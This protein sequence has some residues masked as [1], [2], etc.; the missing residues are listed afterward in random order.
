MQYRV[1]LFNVVDS[2]VVTCTVIAKNV[3]IRTVNR[4]MCVNRM[5]ESELIKVTS[6]FDK[7]TCTVNLPRYFE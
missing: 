1:K 4:T 3:A 6:C 7:T 5:Q 2:S